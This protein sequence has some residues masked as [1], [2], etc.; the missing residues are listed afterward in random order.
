MAGAILQNEVRIFIIHSWY[1]PAGS[2]G[3]QLCQRP[4]CPNNEQLQADLEAHSCTAT[5]VFVKITI[6]LATKSFNGA[7]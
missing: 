5:L 4:V 3:S 1:V 7:Q 6:T 2:D